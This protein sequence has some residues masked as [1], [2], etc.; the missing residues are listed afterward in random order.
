MPFVSQRLLSELVRASDGARAVFATQNNRAGF[1]FIIP[2]VEL[3]RVEEQIKRGEF[4]IQRLASI[5]KA[6]RLR[7]GLR[8]HRLFNVNTPEDVEIA[9]RLLRRPNVLKGS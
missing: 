2:V 9:E 8:S 1:P 3:R 6:R 4:S 5:V 7:V